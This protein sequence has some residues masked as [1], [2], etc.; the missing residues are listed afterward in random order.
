MKTDDPRIPQI[1]EHWGLAHQFL[2]TIEE[3][4]ELSQAICKYLDNPT[5]ETADHINEELEDVQIM[6]DQLR[7]YNFGSDDWREKKLKRTKMIVTKAKIRE[8]KLKK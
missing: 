7:Y 5:D 1:A 6:I 4:S 2:K 8:I 3:S